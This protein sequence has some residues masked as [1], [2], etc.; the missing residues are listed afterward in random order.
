MPIH[1]SLPRYKDVA[2]AKG[3]ELYEAL[4]EKDMARAEAIYQRCEREAR[5]LL[6]E[7]TK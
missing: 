4:A 3:S 7:K 6:K 1:E 5:E 2:A